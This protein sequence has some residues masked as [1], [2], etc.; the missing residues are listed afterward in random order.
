MKAIFCI[1]T[2]SETYLQLALNLGLSIKANSTIDTVLLHTIEPLNGLKWSQQDADLI[3][4]YA[5]D[6][7]MRIVPDEKY[8][9]APLEQAHYIKLSAYQ[10]A[11]DLGYSEVLILDSD[12]LVVPSKSPE[13]WFD[14]VG[15][16]NFTAYCNAYFDFTTGKQSKAGYTFWCEPKEAMQKFELTDKMPQINASFIYFKISE[17]AEKVFQTAKN[18]WETVD[19]SGFEYEKY[20]GSK[21]EEMCL[22]IA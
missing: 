16:T 7:M 15:E 20:N 10:I 13:K 8:C 22:N 6:K 3:F 17:Q 21:T 1:A 18:I 11:K 19:E 2:G 9:T 5:F 4:G 12:T 14:E